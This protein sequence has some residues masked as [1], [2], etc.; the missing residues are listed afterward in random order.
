MLDWRVSLEREQSPDAD[1]R[2]E[3]LD[4]IR[5]VDQLA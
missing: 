1:G 2:K 3:L 5:V 4:L